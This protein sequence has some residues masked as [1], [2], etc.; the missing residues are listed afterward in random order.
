[1]N[2]FS[3]KKLLLGALLLLTVFASTVPVRAMVAKSTVEE[4]YGT[5][6][7][8][9]LTVPGRPWIEEQW[10]YTVENVKIT[11]SFVGNYCLW[12]DYFSMNA[13]DEEYILAE[14]KKLQPG[15]EWT[16]EY[17]NGR[18]RWWFNSQE[19]RLSKRATGYSLHTNDYIRNVLSRREQ[20]QF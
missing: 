13:L 14:M 5:D 16:P 3:R 6:Y 10:I 19:D 20:W 4:V 2:T 11:C 15:E 1:M 12:I 9:I 7:T 8:R 18:I 17:R